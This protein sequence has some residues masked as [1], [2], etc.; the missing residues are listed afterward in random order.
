M[1]SIDRTGTQA[2][3]SFVG[4]H[5][6]ISGDGRF[7]AF[8]SSGT[9]YVPGDVNGVSDLFVRDC[10]TRSNMWD[11][12][13]SRVIPAGNAVGSLPLVFSPDGRFLLFQSRATNHVPGLAFTND[14]HHLYLR[15]LHSNVT[16]L[17]TISADGTQPANASV[18]Q[19]GAL[20]VPPFLTPD[21]RFVVFSSPATNMV[22][23]PDAN[24]STDVFC[25]DTVTGTTELVT[26]SPD[27]ASSLDRPSFRFDA[28]T[29]ARFVAFVTSA[30]N[31][32]AGVVNTSSWPQVYW[33][34]RVAG[35]N[36]WVSFNAAGGLAQSG[37]NLLGLSSDGRYVGF[38]TLD[39][40]VVA[41]VTDV[42]HTQDFFIRDMWA[43][44]TW[45]VTKSTNGATTSSRSSEG[46]FSEN[47]EWLLFGN[48]SGEVMAGITN[49]SA[50]SFNI[51]A[52]HLPTRSNAIISVSVDGHS[53]ANG[54]ASPNFAVPSASGRFVAYTAQASNLV[55]G[56]TNNVQRLYL[57]DTAGHY[58]RA[59]LHEQPLVTAAFNAARHQISHDERWIFFLSPHNYD[60]SVTKTGG[61]IELFRVPLFAPQVTA[62]SP[63]ALQADGL[64]GQAYALQIS[65]HLPAWTNT[66]T[67]VADA[68]G[69][70]TWPLPPSL[71]PQLFFRLVWE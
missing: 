10:L 22:P 3:G 59:V 45:L 65:T 30:T 51:F 67:T 69:K 56:S 35:T 1:V 40:N 70:A 25:R 48:T 39:S 38:T 66:I 49:H 9:N 47:G 24:Q 43:G 33:R 8:S 58:T 42:N 50:N 13:D 2:G 26:V 44:E 11:T 36:A 54:F 32:V 17:V 52:H 62:F 5:Y 57:R 15:D 23:Q 61:A 37:A 18:S 41:G 4:E 34:D 31:V 16:T 64:A 63:T 27:G 60:P 7:A 12:T 71:A 46:R 53:G 55:P 14:S 19:M 68:G 29:N 20:P 28:S 21:G 6:A